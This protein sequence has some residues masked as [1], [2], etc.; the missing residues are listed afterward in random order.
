M[1]HT[2]PAVP[3]ADGQAALELLQAVERWPDLTTALGRFT[4]LR[5]S[6]LDG[7]TF[8]IEVI[9]LP[10]ARTPM[11]LRAY[12]SVRNVVTDADPDALDAWVTRLRFAGVSDSGDPAPIPSGAQVHAAFDLVTHEGHFLG[13]AVNRILL[14]RLEGRS[15]IRAA[16]SWDP[17]PAAIAT[18]YDRIGRE[19]QHAM[20]GMAAPQDSM[21]HQVAAAVGPTSD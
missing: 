10:T 6:G 11:L 12:V 20:W 17:M 21:L 4:P 2:Y 7:Q 8:E 16:A 15:Y 3:L 19:V 5:A 1:W 14:Y 18:V 13:N 9:G